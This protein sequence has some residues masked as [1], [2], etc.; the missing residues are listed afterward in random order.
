M[1][2]VSQQIAVSA[3]ALTDDPRRAPQLSRRLGFGGLVFPAAS[4]A[5][6]VTELS[7]TGRREFR[8]LFS[9]QDQQLVALAADLGPRGLSPGADGDRGH[10]PLGRV[11][12]GAPGV[13]A[14]PVFAD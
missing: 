10:A 7:A 5:V 4:S 1:A 6:D 14:P 2:S 13:A 8:Q 11:M 9:S 12:G 3:A